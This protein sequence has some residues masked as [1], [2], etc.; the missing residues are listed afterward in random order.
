ML[1]DIGKALRDQAKDAIKEAKLKA[2]SH[3]EPRFG[4]EQL[5]EGFRSLGRV[6]GDGVFVHSS[7][8]S[9]G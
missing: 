1:K 5:A 6:P 3:L 4:R 7:L 2:R 9:L 8:K